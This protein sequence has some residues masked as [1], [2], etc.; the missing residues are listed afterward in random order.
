VF[1]A[2]QGGYRLIDTAAA[3]ENEEA[4]GKAITK[5]WRDKGRDLGHEVGRGDDSG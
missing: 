1:D 2:L 3:Y 5:K 4:V